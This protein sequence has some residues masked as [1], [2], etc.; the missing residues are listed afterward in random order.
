MRVGLGRPPGRQ[1]AADF[2]LSSF[3]APQRRE[4][5]LH[6][7]TAADATESIITDGLDQTQNRYNR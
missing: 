1:D 4:L 5:D 2:V 3:S 6:L 7:S